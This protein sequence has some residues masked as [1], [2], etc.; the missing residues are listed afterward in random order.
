MAWTGNNVLGGLNAVPK[1][2]I[3]QSSIINGQQLTDYFREHSSDSRQTV[4]C[5]PLIIA[6]R[7]IP[8]VW[9]VKYVIAV[10]TQLLKKRRLRERFHNNA[11]RF[12]YPIG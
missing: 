5:C 1:G 8:S 9:S 7:R 12:G 11:P 2:W 3:R 4:N 6:L 10:W